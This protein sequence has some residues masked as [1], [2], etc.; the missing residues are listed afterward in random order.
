MSE[1]IRRKTM[2]MKV[3]VVGNPGVGKTYLIR[4]LTNS[5]EHIEPTEEYEV[6]LYNVSTKFAFMEIQLWDCSGHHM[7]FHKYLR[8]AFFRH[9]SA[10]LLVFNFSR[11]DWQ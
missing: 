6:S 3:C 4:H 8:H 11:P 9:C 1:K 5:E 10:A 7:E 2:R